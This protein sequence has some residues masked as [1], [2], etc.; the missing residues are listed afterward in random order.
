MSL[1]IFY[2]TSYRLDM[3]RALLRPSLGACDNAV[4]LPHWSFRSVK[5]EELMLV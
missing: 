1:G 3:F 2:F 4:E 5:M